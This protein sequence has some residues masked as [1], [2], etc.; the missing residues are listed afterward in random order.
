MNVELVSLRLFNQAD[1]AGALITRRY[2]QDRLHELRSHPD[3][4][5]CNGFCQL[6]RKVNSASVFRCAVAWQRQ[7]NVTRK[8]AQR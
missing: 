3:G 5:R 4:C 6:A 7:V 2:V 1:E 8:L